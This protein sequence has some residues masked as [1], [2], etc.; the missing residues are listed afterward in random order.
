MKQE[1]T[2]EEKPVK[3]DYFSIVRLMQTDIPG[4]KNLLTG[5]TYIK[6][7][8]WAISN[9]TCKLL[10]FDHKPVIFCFGGSQGSTFINSAFIRLFQ[11]FDAEWQ[12]IHLTGKHEYLKIS[13][14]YN[15]IKNNK[16]V[17]DFYYNT[18]VL[19]SAADLVIGRAGA[20]T[21]GEISYFKLPSILIP[22]PRAG[23]HQKENAFYFK[24]RGAALVHLQKEFSF[25][26]F[27]ES[28]KKLICD[29]G[30]RQEMTDNLNDIKLGVS[31]EDFCNSFSV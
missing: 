20:V 1:E 16:F 12:I 31:F 25:D 8:S 18:E 21:L 24:D 22:H 30:L 19:Y 26:D 13:E 7:I 9:A 5:L 23:G 28:V 6:G 10:N 17:A 14:F 3:K 27:R 2:K 11:G 29:N 4:N 15:K